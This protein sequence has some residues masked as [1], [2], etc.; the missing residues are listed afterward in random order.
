MVKIVKYIFLAIT[1]CWVFIS[2][3]K[4]EFLN[5][6]RDNPLDGAN[7]T[8]MQG[9][10]ALKFAECYVSSDNNGDGKVNKGETV[11]LNVS[12]K[13]T[14]SSTAKGVKATFSSTSQYVSDFSPTMQ[15]SYGD[16]TANSVKWYNNSKYSYILEF[17]IANSTPENT[18][19]PIEISIRDE[20]NNT[21]TSSFVVT[22]VGTDAI[23]SYNGYQ[24]SSDNNGDGKVNKGET[25]KLNVSLKNTGSSTAKGVKATFSSTSQYVS[26]FSPTMQVSYGDITANSVKWYNNSK[27]SYILEFTIANSTPENTDIPIEISIRDESDNTWTSSFIV[28]VQ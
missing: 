11:K 28:T 25:V 23:V 26:D 10:V 6:K 20:S 17:T 1:S 4:Y 13:N 16:I 14:G 24:V 19:I 21:W 12:L 8:N 7:N 22:V 3:E 27:Y 15:V 5:L 2:C 9:G 18:D